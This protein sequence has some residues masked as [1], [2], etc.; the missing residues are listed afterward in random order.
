MT[1]ACLRMGSYG[2]MEHARI[3][4]IGFRIY[5][6]EEIRRISLLE[7]TSCESLNELGHIIPNGLYDLRMGKS[8]VLP[9][10]TVFRRVTD[11][12]DKV[13][14]PSCV[15]WKAKII[16]GG[17]RFLYFPVLRLLYLVFILFIFFLELSQCEKLSSCQNN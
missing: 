12:K 16:C 5:T 10:N 7:I 15:A 14:L 8:C 6:A 13:L 11:G 17:F 4:D 1:H 9:A 2:Q 3:E